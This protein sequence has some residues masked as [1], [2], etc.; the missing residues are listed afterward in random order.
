MILY[1]HGF[2]STGES[3]K[4]Q[5]FKQAFNE[6]NIEVLTPTYPLATPQKSIDFLV[7]YIDTKLANTELTP[8]WQIFGSSMGGFYGEI[9]AEKY[10]VPLVMIN[11]ALNPVSVFRQH[12]GEYSHPKTGEKIIINETF[13]RSLASVRLKTAIRSPTC[14]LLDKTDEVIPYQF[15]FDKYQKAIEAK[16][17]AFEGGDHAFQHLDAAWPDVKQ[18][19]LDLSKRCKATRRLGHYV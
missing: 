4:G 16:V 2:L 9:L 3:I 1:L 17:I 13:I 6:L 11:P 7:D 15:A 18:F 5:W 12:I 8:A 10:K 14:L 19:V